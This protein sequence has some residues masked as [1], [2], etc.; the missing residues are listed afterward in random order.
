ML[1]F[2]ETSTASS[3]S[4]DT[5]TSHVAKTLKKDTSKSSSTSV[6]AASSSRRF[7]LPPAP[8]T[9]T[10]LPLVNPHNSIDKQKLILIED[11]PHISNLI[12]RSR[13]H[14]AL[15]NYVTSPRCTYPIV[16]IISDILCTSDAVGSRSSAWSDHQ[17]A[18]LRTLVPPDLISSG[19]AVVI[20][21]ETKSA[22]DNFFLN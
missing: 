19:R 4:T 11:H 12:I 20:K 6:T 21:Y 17:I 22:S 18:S 10:T 8:P 16:L 3:T 5:A 2:N 9:S 15:K 13:V 7:L 1:E 14:A